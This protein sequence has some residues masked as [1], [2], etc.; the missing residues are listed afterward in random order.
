MNAKPWNR[1][2]GSRGESPVLLL[3]VPPG[4]LAALKR[5]ARAR[6]LKPSALAREILERALLKQG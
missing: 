2:K 3:R 6:G 5:E 4:L 1:L